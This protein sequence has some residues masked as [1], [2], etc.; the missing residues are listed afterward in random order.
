MPRPREPVAEVYFVADNTGKLLSVHR[1]RPEA[2]A[3]SD[4]NSILLTVPI[5]GQ[6]GR[7]PHG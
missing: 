2:M 6:T 1:N 4:K 5:T 7:W 3:H